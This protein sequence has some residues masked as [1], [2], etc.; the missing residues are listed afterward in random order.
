MLLGFA[1]RLVPLLV[2][3]REK[4]KGGQTGGGEASVVVL[5]VTVPD[6]EADVTVVVTVGMSV[7]RQPRVEARDEVL[8]VLCHTKVRCKTITCRLLH[9]E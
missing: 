2:P 3:L 4:K 8:G 7:G 6:A 9:C 5:V 1:T